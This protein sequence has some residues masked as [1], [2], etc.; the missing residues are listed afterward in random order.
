[1]F[2]YINNKIYIPANILSYI[3]LQ[4]GREHTLLSRFLYLIKRKCIR[5]AENNLQNKEL[6]TYIP[7]GEVESRFDSVAK[8]CIISLHSSTIL[9][10]ANVDHQQILENC[11]FQEPDRIRGREAEVKINFVYLKRYDYILMKANSE[12]RSDHIGVFQGLHFS[13]ELETGGSDSLLSNVFV[14]YKLPRLIEIDNTFTPY[15]IIKCSKD[16]LDLIFIVPATYL[17]KKFDI[18]NSTHNIILI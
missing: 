7:A 10:L 11:N 5:I 6:H 4:V 3:L 13:E 2:M 9:D 8:I 17:I 12:Q 14:A 15:K 18:L 1:M 16:E